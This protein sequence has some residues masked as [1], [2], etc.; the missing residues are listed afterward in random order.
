MKK[1]SSPQIG[2]PGWKIM[3][4]T[5]WQDFFRDFF[6][7]QIYISNN[8]S[9]DMDV[10]DKVLQEV[11][12]YGFQLGRILDVL[13]VLVAHMPPRDQLSSEEQYTLQQ[14]DEL[15]KQVTDELIASGRGSKRKR[16]RWL[17]GN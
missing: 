17:K 14:F 9:E 7:P 11:G 4:V 3:P 8:F 1:R 10:E 2:F 15:Y 5:D 12:S 16:A 6:N 13:D